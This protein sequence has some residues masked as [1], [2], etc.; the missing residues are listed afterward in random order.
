MQVRVQ[1]EDKLYTMNSKSKGFRPDRNKFERE[2]RE[3][4]VSGPTR[5]P[6]AFAPEPGMTYKKPNQLN[7]GGKKMADEEEKKEEEVNPDTTN[8]EEEPKT[9]T[10]EESSEEKKEDDSE[11]SSEKESSEEDSE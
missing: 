4:I 6:G 7:K 1:K 11:G 2:K 5:K 10:S 3:T 8:S 9:E